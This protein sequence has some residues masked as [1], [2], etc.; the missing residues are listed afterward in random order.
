MNMNFKN[1]VIEKIVVPAKQKI[2]RGYFL[3]KLKPNEICN[4]CKKRSPKVFIV[5]KR[6]FREQ[7][8]SQICRDQFK[9]DP[10]F[11]ERFVYEDLLYE[12]QFQPLATLLAE[13]LDLNT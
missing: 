13:H 9:K 7:C 1:A 10:S 6:T 3:I 2:E 12:R 4:H 5:S 8:E 11:Y